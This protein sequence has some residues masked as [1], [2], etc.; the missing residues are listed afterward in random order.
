MRRVSCYEKFDARITGIGV[1]VE[2]TWWNEVLGL[3][4]LIS[5]CF[6]GLDYSLGWPG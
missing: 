1:T 2:K 5:K 4:M 3:K 6:T